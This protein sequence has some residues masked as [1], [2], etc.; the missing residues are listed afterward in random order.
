MKTIKKEGG[1]GGG[2]GV[3]KTQTTPM[4]SLHSVIRT[5]MGQI[6]KC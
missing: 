6:E 3:K 1:G 5:K 4:Y 2:G